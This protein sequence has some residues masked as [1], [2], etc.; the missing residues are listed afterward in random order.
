MIGL[1]QKSQTKNFFHY[2]GTKAI[3]SIIDKQCTTQTRKHDKWEPHEKLK[4]KK[5]TYEIGTENSVLKYK[6]LART[7]GFAAYTCKEGKLHPHL[8]ATREGY[9]IR[10]V[11]I[12]SKLTLSTGVT[13]PSLRVKRSERDK[14]W[15]V[16]PCSRKAAP[17]SFKSLSILS[18]N[19]DLRSESD[20]VETAA[21]FPKLT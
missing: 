8:K 6:T 15:E 3:L 10:N 17:C 20:I 7:G 13:I 14:D 21:N 5:I 1:Y 16:S 4:G 11:L 18:Y 19:F 2:Y 9:S 12:H